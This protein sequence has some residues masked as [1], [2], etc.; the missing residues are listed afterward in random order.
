MSGPKDAARTHPEGW[1]VSDE[2]SVH[3][4]VLRAGADFQAIEHGSRPEHR[5]KLVH[6]RFLC[7]VQT[8]TS[9]WV[10]AVDSKRRFRAFHLDRIVNDEARAHEGT[11]RPRRS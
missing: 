9:S 8:P 10:E 1:T 6:C 11:P 7:Y 4:R 2:V 5:R 3:G